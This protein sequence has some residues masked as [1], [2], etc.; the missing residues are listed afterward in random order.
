MHQVDGQP[1]GGGGG[2]GYGCGGFRQIFGVGWT[3]GRRLNLVEVMVGSEGEQV[4]AGLF[5]NGVD[6][7]AIVG[8]KVVDEEV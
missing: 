4:Q 1:G 3:R 2:G 8:H 6:G 7:G 5:L